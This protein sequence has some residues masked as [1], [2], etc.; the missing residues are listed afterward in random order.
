M[1]KS[2]VAK[3]TEIDLELTTLNGEQAELGVK[4][5]IILSAQGVTN[6]VKE[7]TMLENKNDEMKEANKKKKVE[8]TKEKEFSPF[9]IMGVEL[10]MLYDK[11]KEWWT[12]SFDPNSLND[13]M[14]HVAETLAGVK[15]SL[16]SSKSSLR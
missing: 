8:E 2:F 13:I 4:S 14:Q 11:P 10:S 6:M 9:E 5:N 3:A 16:K 7:W 12:E 15:K 1:A